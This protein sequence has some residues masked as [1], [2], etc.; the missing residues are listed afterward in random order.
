MANKNNPKR[1]KQLSAFEREKLFQMKQTQMSLRDIAKALER[2]V[3]TVSRELKRNHHGILKRYLPDTAEKKCQERRA[4]SRK[5]RYVDKKPELKSY[6][7]QK[8]KQDWSPEQIAG[9]MSMDI[10]QYLN[11]E[12]IYQYIYSADGQRQ[13]LRL[14]LRRR[15][16]K[17]GSKHGRRLYRGV[18]PGRVD[19][20][21]RPEVVEGRK[22]FG[23]WEGDSMLFR[24]QTQILATQVERKS[25]FMVV[26][27][28]SIKTANARRLCMTNYFASLPE[29][30]RRSLTVDNGWEFSEHRQF[31]QATKVPVYF[32]KPYAAY[33]R[34]TNEH[35]NGL[36]RW[37]LPR[38]IDLKS[39]ET[40]KLKAIVSRINSRPRKCLGFLKPIEVFYD[41]L[42]KCYQKPLTVALRN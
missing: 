34:G 5:T 10:A 8:L 22:V 36:L 39:L 40:D 23:H 12:S 41:E 2:S 25:R 16:S 3:S 15:R 32:A 20:D 6:I 28:P 38:Q 1:Y 7:E 24:K 33:Q 42:K 35:H 29:S 21:E 31:T 9:R 30:A 18:I 26:L 27:E 11:Y 37:Y 13:D 4:R 14:L 19:I 17:R